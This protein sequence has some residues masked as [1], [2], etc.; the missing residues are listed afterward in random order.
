MCIALGRDHASAAALMQRKNT[1][2]APRRVANAEE[3]V[4][5]A[6]SQ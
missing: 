4:Q 5:T 2:A 1:A 3:F 6:A